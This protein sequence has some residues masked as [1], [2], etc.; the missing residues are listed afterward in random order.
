M[1]NKIFKLASSFKMKCSSPMKQVVD[2]T[3][4]AKEQEDAAKKAVSSYKSNK[5]LNPSELAIEVA[6]AGD[7]IAAAR[8]NM[9]LLD[10][11]KRQAIGNEA[12][13]ETRKANFAGTTVVK[14]EVN[15]KKTGA[16]TVYKRK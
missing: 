12:A 15:D 5:K 7:S 10:K 6:A 1:M 2:P 8:K 11:D 4:K 13:N 3:Q 16:K 14:E 9:N